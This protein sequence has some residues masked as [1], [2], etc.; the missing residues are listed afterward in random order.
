L[1]LKTPADL[2]A[3]LRWLGLMVALSLAPL[4]V[5]ADSMV[6]QGPVLDIQVQRGEE[7]L[8]I[9]SVPRLQQGDQLLVRPDPAS[10]AR[11]E[12][13]LMLGLITPA[14]N[15]VQTQAIDVNRLE[16]HARLDIVSDDHAPVI[17]LAPQLRNLFGLYTS[18]RESSALL[19]EVI[20]S[21]PQRFYDLQRLDE[22]NQVI[23]A[24][25]QGLD[26]LLQ[27]NAA[28]G[29]AAARAMAQK[30]GVSQVDPECFRNQTVNTQCLA[31]SIVVNKDFALPSSSDLG[32]LAGAKGMA[33]LNG[34]LADKLKVFADAGDFLSHKFRDQ[35]DFA[36]TF[37]R[38]WRD[39][40]STQLFSLTRFR[41][42]HI[43]TAYVYVPAWFKGRTP[44]LS[45]ASASPLC[46][47]QGSLE[48]S[49]ADR[50]PVLNHWH[51]WQMQ[52]HD[53]RTG[54]PLGQAQDL[55][56]VSERST[57]RYTATPPAAAGPWVTATVQGRFG[58]EPVSLPP[59]PLVVPPSDV[60][61]LLADTEALVAGETATW[62]LRSPQAACVQALTLS[63]DDAVLAR[64]AVGQPD[65][66]AADLREVSPGPAQLRVDLLG[67]NSATVPLRV[68]PPRALVRSVTHTEL[69]EELTVSGQRLGRIA[70]AQLGALACWPTRLTHE[71]EGMERLHMACGP[72]A[73]HNARLP[74]RVVL[75]HAQDEPAPLTLA[76][77]KKASPPRV[78]L[79]TAPH[80][81]LVR[82]SAKARRWGLDSTPALL[83]DD[84]SM[85]LLLQATDGYTLGRGGYSL[86][87]RFADDPAT[88]R[89]PITAALMLDLAHQE[90]RTRQAVHFQGVT[91]PTVVN[92]LEYRVVQDATGLA[93]DW[94]ALQRSVLMLP[95][96]GELVCAPS[97]G[98]WWLPGHSLHLIDAVG[99]AG[100]PLATATLQP[101]PDGLCLLLPQN[102]APTALALS[103]HWVRETVFSVYAEAGPRCPAP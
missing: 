56:F 28:E 76:L 68:L 62:R 44:A 46:L 67:A 33:D 93:S 61:Q 66:L 10:M 89:Q 101:C 17:V 54:I 18:F 57:F 11:G 71:T 88:A 36:A 51:S 83:S 37:G 25:A 4:G 7:R 38:R 84:S 32:M 13:I 52:W 23:S 69:D 100:S 94:V 95:E 77:S 81:L 74:D 96:F 80:A 73:K 60:Q 14:G 5:W 12:W 59:L 35:Y 24:L 2:V 3:W 65:R 20:H 21:D 103:L 8:P 1:N 86:Q 27:G 58:F 26:Q 19:D 102:S 47:T 42:G 64:H 98:H 9:F 39:S 31:L 45:V 78:R 91:L 40:T 85:H 49:S 6:H 41:Q 99:W 34:F 79:S 70:R 29:V 50:M 53:P 90:L 63:R 15:R 87:L 48:V 92:P 22:V 55:V 97:A 72:E 75:H 16:G 82:P 30:F 43:K